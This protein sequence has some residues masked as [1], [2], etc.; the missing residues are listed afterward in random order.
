MITVNLTIAKEVHRDFTRSARG[1]LLS[2]LDVDFQRAL[3]TGADT[4]EIVAQKNLLRNAPQDP[5]I[6]AASTITEL[7]STWDEALLGPSPYVQV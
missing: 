2:K 5:A 4:T 6:D 7:K 1:P 3:E